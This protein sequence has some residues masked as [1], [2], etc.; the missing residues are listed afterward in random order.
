MIRPPPLLIFPWPP[1]L[2][3]DRFITMPATGRRPC[4]PIRPLC[5][6]YVHNDPDF[7]IKE[8]YLPWSQAVVVDASNFQPEGIFHQCVA[9]PLCLLTWPFFP[10][11]RAP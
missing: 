9:T 7:E 5:R 10:A 11:L 6:S 4:H 1:P 8:I 2:V 3:I